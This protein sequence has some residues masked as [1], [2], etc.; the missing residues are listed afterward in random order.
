MRRRYGVLGAVLTIV[1]L[2]AVGYAAVEY[3]DRSSGKPGA[4]PATGT[5]GAGPEGGSSTQNPG[6]S[7]DP[8]GVGQKK[9]ASPS[10]TPT[11]TTPTAS[12][13]TPSPSSPST[14][15]RGT[16]RTTPPQ[17]GIDSPAWTVGVRYRAGDRVTHGGAAYVCRQGHTSQ[18]DWPP[19]DTPT[20]WSPA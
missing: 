16:P 12:S 17:R 7:D 11:T 6:S 18:A 15:G 5:A 13:A 3:A 2:L 20:L 14:T 1:F 4:S 10:Q 19:Q 9:S 8:V